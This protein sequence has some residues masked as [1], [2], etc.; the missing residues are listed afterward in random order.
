MDVP[1]VNERIVH[2]ECALNVYRPTQET[3]GAPRNCW[4][5]RR[6]RPGP[7]RRTAVSTHRS[8][9]LTER[10]VPGTDEL[11][12]HVTMVLSDRTAPYLRE[13]EKETRAVI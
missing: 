9:L 10:S 13:R 5:G 4:A 8:K 11:I 3:K 6:A 2:V 7:W 1:G 12:V